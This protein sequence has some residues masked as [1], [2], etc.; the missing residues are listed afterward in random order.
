MTVK[1]VIREQKTME[2]RIRENTVLTFPK[3]ETE[4][5]ILRQV[6]KGDTETV[7]RLYSNDAVMQYRGADQ[8]RSILEAENLIRHFEQLFVQNAGLRWGLAFRGQEEELIGTAGI[9][10]IDWPHFRGEIGYELSPSLWNKGLMTEALKAITAYAFNQLNLHTLEANIAPANSASQRVLEKL[11]F[12]KEAHFKENW[13]YKGW[14][15]SAIYTLHN[16]V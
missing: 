14:W 2:N 13:Y 8:Y 1:V 9:N 12:V 4:R 11:G 6:C 10:K 3:L 7:Y 15:D 16:P 5:L